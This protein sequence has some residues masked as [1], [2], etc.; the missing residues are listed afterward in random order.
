MLRMLNFWGGL[1]SAKE[2][3]N[4]SRT[5]GWKE[6]RICSEGYGSRKYSIAPGV[7]MRGGIGSS[8]SDTR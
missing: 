2:D 3:V 7:G 1:K 4:H 8:V 5:Y 6:A